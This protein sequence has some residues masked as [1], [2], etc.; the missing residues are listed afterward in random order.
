M[1]LLL[2]DNLE[3]TSLPDHVFMPWLQTA[4]TFEPVE[5]QRS[6]CAQIER[7]WF[8]LKVGI[9]HKYFKIG[10]VACGP[11]FLFIFIFINVRKELLTFKLRFWPEPKDQ[12]LNDSWFK[13]REFWPFSVMKFRDYSWTM[14]SPFFHPYFLKR[15]EKLYRMMLSI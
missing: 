1:K 14:R 8:E 4:I 11:C 13:I 7:L 5:L 2:T 12:Q 10:L 6:A 15:N 9:S 3:I